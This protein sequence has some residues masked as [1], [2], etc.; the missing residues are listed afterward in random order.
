MTYTRIGA[1]RDVLQYF[2]VHYWPVVFI[3]YEYKRMVGVAMQYLSYLHSHVIMNWVANLDVSEGNPV[4]LIQIFSL[5]ETSHT[6][7]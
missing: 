4:N 3:G 5:N 7:T 1:V 2:R 6:R